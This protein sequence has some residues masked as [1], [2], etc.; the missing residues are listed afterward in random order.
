M[1]KA[2]VLYH[3]DDCILETALLTKNDEKLPSKP[4]RKMQKQR[5]LKQL[6]TRDAQGRTKRTRK[7]N[8]IK[9][10]QKFDFYFA[11]KYN[12]AVY[13]IEMMFLSDTQDTMPRE[14]IFPFYLS[15]VHTGPPL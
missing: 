1:C 13:A 3:K 14:R 12:A 6:L 5:F 8:N 4:K 10:R 2:S 15:R 7:A 11:L 9:L